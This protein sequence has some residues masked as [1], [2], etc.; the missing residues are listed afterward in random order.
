M[1]A[2]VMVFPE[3]PETLQFRVE[4]L[5]SDATQV[6]LQLFR[7]AG[8]DEDAGDARLMKYPGQCRLGQ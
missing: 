7:G 6:F 3:G 4:R 2:F 8:S 1:S 5:G